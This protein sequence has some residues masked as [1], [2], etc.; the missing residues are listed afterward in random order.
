M[1]QINGN[2]DIRY[3]IRILNLIE[4]RTFIEFLTFC[5]QILPIYMYERVIITIK[6]TYITGRVYQKLL[7]KDLGQKVEN[8]IRWDWR[9]E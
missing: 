4:F 3:L 8:S 9:F 2:L 7:K 5:P 6:T 1:F